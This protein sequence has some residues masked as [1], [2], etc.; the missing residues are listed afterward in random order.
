MIVL[1]LTGLTMALLLKGWHRFHAH[2]RHESER[3]V[4]L[5]LAEAGVDRAIWELRGSGSDAEHRPGPKHTGGK[6]T[7]LQ[8]GSY[9]VRVL[10]VPD[11][12]DER[13]IESTGDV[14]YQSD[15]PVARTV[16]VRVR[17]RPTESGAAVEVLE[18]E[19]VG[20]AITTGRVRRRTRIGPRAGN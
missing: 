12:R 15:A 7:A 20:R 5:A 1:A 17:L 19:E 14:P 13:W 8:T 18:W 2:L 16:R 9:T 10:P 6:D 4:T 11:R 3:A